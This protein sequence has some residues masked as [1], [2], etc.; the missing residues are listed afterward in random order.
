MKI[1]GYEV[2]GP[3]IDIEKLKLWLKKDYFKQLEKISIS[4]EFRQDYK[5]GSC[6]QIV[7][8]NGI[9]NHSM[10]CPDILNDR[11]NYT[12]QIRKEKG[13]P[14]KCVICGDDII[15]DNFKL[16]DL[17][18][19]GNN[20]RCEK[21]SCKDTIHNIIF[22]KN[23]F[24]KKECI[25]CGTKFW[26]VVGAATC[27]KECHYKLSSKS[28]KQLWE[29]DKKENN[30]RYKKHL[31][32]LLDVCQ[33]GAFAN[34]RKNGIWNKGLRGEEYLKH[35]DKEDGT[36]SLIEGLK[37]NSIF[38]RKGLKSQPEILMEKYLIGIE[39][40][41]D[42]RYSV[43]HG[44]ECK[45]FKQYDFSLRFDDV[46]VIIEVDGDYYHKSKLMFNDKEDREET[47]KYDKLK[48]SIIEVHNNEI[49]KW[50]KN[51]NIIR[52]WE[53]DINNDKDTVVNFLEQIIKNE[54]KNGN[55]FKK[56]IHKIKEYYEIKS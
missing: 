41:L 28:L 11:I 1:E 7:Q 47:R 50:N 13:L 34:Y 14:E 16:F 22:T 12:R 5:C 27:S 32:D 20:Y 51:W 6:G 49:K 9:N 35:Y 56:I 3:K 53:S 36:N 4:K 2:L 26:S 46:M 30:E 37:K 25:V 55:E 54:D 31:K 15:K 10:I 17:R 33:E 44:N 8:Y 39:P 45:Q 43:F 40:E 24:S 23:M 29:N 48:D 38:M 18:K 19:L 21:K 42:Y 52:F